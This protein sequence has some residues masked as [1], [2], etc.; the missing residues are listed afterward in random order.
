MNKQISTSSEPLATDTTMLESMGYKQ[1]LNRRMNSFSNFA[2]SLSTICILAG[3]L[4]SFHLGFSAVGGAS[5]GLGWP[6]G[7]LFSLIIAASMAQLA[8]A[9]PTAGGLYHWATILGGRGWGWITAWFN[10]VGLVTVLAAINLG[11]YIFAE[12]SVCHMLGIK[13]AE[14]SPNLHLWYQGIGVALI[15]VSQGLINYLGIRLTTLLTDFSGYLILVV[16]VALTLSLL[17]FAPDFN[18]SRLFTFINNSGAP[19]GDVWPA[20]QNIGMLFCLGLLLPAYTITGFDASTHTAEETM[21]AQI[22]V[23]RGILRSVGVSGFA[24]WIMLMAMVLAIPSLDQAALQG[25]NV[26]F[27]LL[28]MVLPPWVGGLLLL[29]I[30]VAQYL[31]GLATVTS[32]SRMMYAF[33]RD[34][35]LPFSESLRRISPRHLTPA[36]A[37]WTVVCLAIGFTIYAP[38]YSTIT[39]V[40]AIFLYLSYVIPI[41][42][43]FFAHGKRWSSF[44]PWTLGI[45]F[46]PAAVA[47]VL[48]CV[49]LVFIGVQPPNDKA[50]SVLCWVGLLMTAVWFG[51]EKRRF[52]GPF[53]GF[54]RSQVRSR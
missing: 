1:E 41:A 49:G 42:L 15:T 10:L 39:V 14:I 34:G 40:C 36:P 46:K 23:P 33:A 31:C 18:L 30:I 51:F 20:S 53:R 2:I 37:V 45:W 24:G 4:T 52:K 21:H 6:L 27:W 19:G 44:G 35:G 28:Q 3:G 5:V 9:F 26:F 22:N 47:G 11:M 16:A 12:I 29:G 32:A 38:V 7:C 25:A 50:L 54:Y 43:G 48:G 17:W 8:S 13:V